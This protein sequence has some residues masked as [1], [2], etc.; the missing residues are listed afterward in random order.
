MREV[1]E[2]RV[3]LEKPRYL[4]PTQIGKRDPDIEPSV[5]LNTY[6]LILLK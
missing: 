6:Y 1:S 5:N 4:Y 2:Y 3:S